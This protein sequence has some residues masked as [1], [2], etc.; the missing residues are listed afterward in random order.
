MLIYQ[1]LLKDI[2]DTGE[3]RQDRTG[4]GTKSVFGY[5]MEFDLDQGFPLLTTK[6]LHLPSIIYELLWFLQG[7]TNIKYLNDNGVS[8]WNPWADGDG[9]L[10]RVYGAQWRKWQKPDGGGHVDQIQT[11]IDG[12]ISD[13]HSRRH[14]VTAWNPGE[15]DQMALPPCHL[16]L[17]FYIDGKHGLH[18]QMY[19]R[20]ADV[21]LGVPF[22]IASY[23]LLLHMIAQVTGLTARRLIWLGGDVHLYN[24]HIEQAQEQLNREPRPLPRVSLTPQQSIFSFDFHHIH[25]L[26]YDPHPHIP[27]PV[28]P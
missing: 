20:S 1:Q 17:Q 2:I 19:Q 21:F 14:L 3:A 28:A 4:I 18:C 26:D 23:A 11:L 6:K 24:N 7:S 9:D 25:I 16:L 8:I 10:G 22:N 27:A 15:M 5:R 12:L 13:P